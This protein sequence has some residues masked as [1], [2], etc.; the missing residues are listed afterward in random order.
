MEI[1]YMVNIAPQ[2]AVIDI[3]ING[4]ATIVWPFGKSYFTLY[5]KIMDL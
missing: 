1:Q 5:Q 3:L 4:S 2:M